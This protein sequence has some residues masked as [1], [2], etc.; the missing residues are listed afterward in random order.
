MRTASAQYVN[1]KYKYIE[2]RKL[3]EMAKARLNTESMERMMPQ[4][5]A[6]IR[7]AAEPAL[8]PS[9]PNVKINMLLGVATGI[10]FG[11]SLAFFLEYLDTSAK[12]MEEVEKSLEL[13]VL[14]VIPKGKLLP[15]GDE[16][17]PDAEAYRILRT[18]VDFSRKKSGATAFTVISGGASEGKSTIVCN[19]ATAWATSGQRVLIVDGDMRRPVQHRLFE[20]SNCVGL[21]DYLKGKVSLD[22]VILRST[23]DNLYLVPAGSA[24]TDVVS[25]LNS[26]AMKHLI[27]TARERFDVILVDSPPILGVSDALIL[28]SLVD[29]SA[30]V[31]QHRHFPRSTLMRVKRAIENIGGHLLGVVLNKVDVRY[32][33]N[34]LYY[35]SYGHYHTKRKN[36]KK[37]GAEAAA[38]TT[39]TFDT[40]EC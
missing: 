5:A 35:T 14:A 27:E 20:M 7:E 36:G 15:R 11:I 9:K 40:D 6:F 32:D 16:N 39:S 31:V 4:K 13:P 12:T 28:V 18:N 8:F 10:I 33:E 1:A 38:K 26:K 21:S 25:L 17:S 19:L 3:L 29:S 37:L 24:S 22:E 34:Y 2:E 30:I 23:L